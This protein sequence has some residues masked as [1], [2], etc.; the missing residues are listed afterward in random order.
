MKICPKC[1]KE[2]NDEAVFCENCGFKLDSA[3][4]QQSRSQKNETAVVSQHEPLQTPIQPNPNPNSK[5]KWIIGLLVGLALLGGVGYALLNHSNE[6]A[7][8][9]TEQTSSP[10][11]TKYDKIIA[12]AKA[13][14]ING[15]YKKSTIKLATI[16]ASDLGKPEFSA[17][18]E[19][20]DKLIDQNEEGLEE[21]KATG[22]AQDTN[23][24]SPAPA[25]DGQSSFVG[26][27]AKWANNYTFYYNQ[28]NQKQQSLKISDNGGVTQN[29]HDGTQYFGHASITGSGGDVLSYVTNRQYPSSMPD[30]KVINPNVKITVNWDNG[31]S[32]VFYGYLSYSSRLAL[33]DGVA[34][35]SGVNEVWISY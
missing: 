18:K 15:D 22:K 21:E 11:E 23:Q 9:A 13:L 4:V 8:D 10:D 16:P 29:N 5:F 1:G 26:D 31:G 30:T 6:T 2:N 17:I 3:S 33:T 12:E 27:Y 14:T 7:N 34:K 35:G 19:E 25:S 24:K 28:S 32:Q 20:V